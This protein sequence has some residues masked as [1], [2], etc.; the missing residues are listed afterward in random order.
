RAVA[1]GVAPGRRQGIGRGPAAHQPQPP[2]RIEGGL[3][4]V[5]ELCDS[6]IT[7]RSRYLTVL[8]PGP[9]LDLVLAD[10]SNP[11]ALAYQL[12]NVEA[13]LAEVGGAPEGDLA[14][15]AGRLRAEVEAMVERVAS[16]EE[17]ALE[18]SRL[19]RSLRELAVAVAALSDAIA[20]RYFSHVPASQSLGF[21]DEEPIEG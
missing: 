9:V 16:S 2:A 7:Y 11:R 14:M 5:L 3:R 1:R 6:V 8:Q 21:G 18:A 12:R 10:A 20:R 4:L 19:P 15:A 13:R 17:P